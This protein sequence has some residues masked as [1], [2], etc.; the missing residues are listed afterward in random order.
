MKVLL[1]MFKAESN[2]YEIGYNVGYIAFSVIKI[3]ITV[4]LWSIGI[5]WTKRS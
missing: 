3:V 1:T 5:R 4:L 2:S